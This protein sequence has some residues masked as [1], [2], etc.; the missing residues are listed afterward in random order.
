MEKPLDD[1]PQKEDFWWH[2][3]GESPTLQVTV[4]WLQANRI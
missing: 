1:Y 4:Q 2:V 3:A